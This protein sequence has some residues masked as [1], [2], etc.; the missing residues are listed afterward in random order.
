MGIFDKARDLA[1]QHGDKARSLAEQHGDKIDN[2]IDKGG[3]LIDERT[4]GRHAAHVDKG[5][6]IAKEQLR[7][8]G[9]QPEA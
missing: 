9:E 2:A 7:R 8:L 1:E 4:G 3:D 6:E 5:Q